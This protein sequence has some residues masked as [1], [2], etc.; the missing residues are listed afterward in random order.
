MQLLY[1]DLSPMENHHVA[2]AFAAM[3]KPGNNFMANLPRKV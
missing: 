3:R 1:N 2:S